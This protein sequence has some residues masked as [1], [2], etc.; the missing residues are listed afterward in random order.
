[1]RTPHLKRQAI[2][3]RTDVRLIDRKR[4]GGATMGP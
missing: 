3:P 2:R 4:S 1:V